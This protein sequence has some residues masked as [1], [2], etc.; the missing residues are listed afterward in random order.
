MRGSG[1][2]EED[3]QSNKADMMGGEGGEDKGGDN[4]K[5]RGEI[6]L[7]LNITIQVR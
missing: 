4:D 1:A 3:G 2:I 7:F 6:P 5:G